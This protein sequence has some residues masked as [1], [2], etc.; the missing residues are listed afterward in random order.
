MTNCAICLA[1]VRKTNCQDSLQS[2]TEYV[3]AAPFNQA[4]DSDTASG[5]RQ[6]VTT[7]CQHC[8]HRGCMIGMI[9]IDRNND[10]PLLCPICRSSLSLQFVRKVMGE[11][12]MPDYYALI[13]QSMKQ[14]Y[15]ELWP[16]YSYWLK[17]SM[18]GQDRSWIEAMFGTIIRVL[19][20]NNVFVVMG[21]EQLIKYR[22]ITDDGPTVAQLIAYRISFLNQHADVSEIP[23]LH[24]GV[25]T[26]PASNTVP[27]NANHQ[28]MT[29]TQN[30][31]DVL[32]SNTVFG[33]LVKYAARAINLY[34]RQWFV[35]YPGSI[36]NGYKFIHAFF[37]NSARSFPLTFR[38][39][40]ASLG[41]IF[42]TEVLL[43]I[44]LCVYYYRDMRDVGVAAETTF[45][46]PPLQELEGGF[47]TEGEKP[48]RTI[49]LGGQ[50]IAREIN[51]EF[52]ILH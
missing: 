19:E 35:Q 48:Y 10:R 44:T 21:T 25:M 33:T 45:P 49:L 52:R 38:I 8:F 14:V 13:D 6:A 7:F 2:R 11:E 16:Q 28:T 30:M 15:I 39:L 27:A 47:S 23:E 9:T 22:S 17:H 26:V 46:V 41:L 18:I 1:K 42:N 29:F 34:F 5:N 51:G 20:E 43:V 12:P 50:P 37:F 40:R 32:E 4:T 31:M 24:P 3:P 36:I